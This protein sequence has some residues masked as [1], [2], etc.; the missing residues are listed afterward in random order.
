MATESRKISLLVRVMVRHC[1]VISVTQ[2]P[3]RSRGTKAENEMHNLALK[4]GTMQRWKVLILGIIIV[5]LILIT[6]F[7]DDPEDYQLKPLPKVGIID[8][9]KT[10]EAAFGETG[11]PYYNHILEG[12]QGQDK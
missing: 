4:G 5:V 12:N 6:G 7:V 11:G 10:Y 1:C 2:R 8:Y 9:G 3:G